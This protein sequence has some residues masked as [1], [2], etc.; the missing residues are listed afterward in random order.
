MVSFY[1][2]FHVQKIHSFST[3]LFGFVSYCIS[4]SLEQQDCCIALILS[5]PI[6][7]LAVEQLCAFTEAPATILPRV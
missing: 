5:K 3:A 2:D 1:A 4:A 6:L 7:M